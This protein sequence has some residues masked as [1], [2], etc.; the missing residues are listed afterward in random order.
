MPVFCPTRQTFC[1]PD[2]KQGLLESPGR[3]PI[4][5]ALVR[6]ARAPAANYATRNIA[7]TALAINAECRIASRE[8]PM[9]LWATC[10][11]MMA[12]SA[13]EPAKA[14]SPIN[15][16]R[17]FLMTLRSPQGSRALAEAAAIPPAPNTASSAPEPRSPFPQQGFSV[18]AARR[19][20]GP[21]SAP[22][23]S[24]GRTR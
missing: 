20:S 21:Q 11:S 3:R 10:P 9:S 5:S 22:R 12:T 17:R 4:D 23:R 13:A 7:S 8:S 18:C 15:K 1:W 2:E 6:S 16:P 14:A 19:R 24:S